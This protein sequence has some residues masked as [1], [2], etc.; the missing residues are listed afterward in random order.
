[1]PIWRGSL[2]RRSFNCDGY[3]FGVGPFGVGPFGVGPFGVKL[4]DCCPC[5]LVSAYLYN[6][7]IS[8]EIVEL[9][10][11]YIC[12][13]YSPLATCVYFLE[14]VLGRFTVCSSSGTPD[15]ISQQLR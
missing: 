13:N 4:L 11:S 3:P 2:W 1:M 14:T 15:I 5:C 12:Y 6:S 7:V 10:G 9:V 8:I